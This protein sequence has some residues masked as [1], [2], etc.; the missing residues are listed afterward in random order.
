MQS[1]P[2]L[3]L[4]IDRYKI[5]ELGAMDNLMPQEFFKFSKQ[6]TIIKH[7]PLINLNYDIIDYNSIFKAPIIDK[8]LYFF[9]IAGPGFINIRVKP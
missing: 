3:R 1:K 5:F 7:I 9:S 4:I 6:A 8:L 2:I